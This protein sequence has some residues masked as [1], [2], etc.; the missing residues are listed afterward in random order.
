MGGLTEVCGSRY[1]TREAFEST[2][3][4]LKFDRR[5]DS[6]SAL[7]PRDLAARPLTRNVRVKRAAMKLLES[8]CL[9]VECI[10]LCLCG[11]FCCLL[12]CFGLAL[13]NLNGS[14]IFASVC[15]W[16]YKGVCVRYL[17]ACKREVDV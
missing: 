8:P 4:R 9:K 3:S 10:D 7:L 17:L 16:S 2:E 5:F 11:A 15:L 6:I 13:L 12:A 1:S 14:Y